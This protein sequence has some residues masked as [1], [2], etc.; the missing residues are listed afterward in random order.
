MYLS[1]P[2]PRELDEYSGTYLILRAVWKNVLDRSQPADTA[3]IYKRLNSSVGGHGLIY[4]L[5]ELASEMPGASAGWVRVS[6][7][8]L[9]RSWAPAWQMYDYELCP[10]SVPL[11][12]RPQAAVASKHK[13]R[14]PCRSW[15]ALWKKIFLWFLMT[16]ASLPTFLS[17]VLVHY[18]KASSLT[19][20]FASIHCMLGFSWGLSTLA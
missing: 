5:I 20:C 19:T 4:P 16:E 13:L 7:V 14:H 1:K 15:L 11:T 8:F 12:C 3:D 6:A 9:V 18:H 2:L 10:L 17:V